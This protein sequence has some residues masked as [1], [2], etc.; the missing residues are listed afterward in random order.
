MWYVV[1][2]GKGREKI[3]I[4]KC[5]NALSTDAAVNIFAPTY[6]YLKRYSG[7]WNLEEDWL[8]PGYVFIESNLPNELENSLREYQLR[9][10]LC[11]LEEA[12]IL[13]M[14]KKEQS[15]RC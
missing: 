1:M 11:V 7:K 12:L 14:K 8:F 9:L 13:Y 15:L 4:E 5:R 3:A 10:F 6:Q 2:A